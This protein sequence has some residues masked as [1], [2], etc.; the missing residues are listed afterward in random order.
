MALPA[1][2]APKPM[3]KEDVSKDGQ[4][5]V[6]VPG[7]E[8]LVMGEDGL[9]TRLVHTHSKKKARKVGFYSHVVSKGMAFK[10]GGRLWWIE[11]HAG[12]GQLFEIETCEVLPGSPLSALNVP[13]PFAGY[14]FAS[15]TAS[16]EGAGTLGFAFGMRPFFVTFAS[17]SQ[18]ISPVVRRCTT[19]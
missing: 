3:Q 4:K 19:S 17:S 12:P 13:T 5:F 16:A 9:V 1:K 18:V 7:Y 11:F 8:S 10:W 14:V 6:P 2:R 15:G